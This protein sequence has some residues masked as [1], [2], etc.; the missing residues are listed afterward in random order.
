MPQPNI[1]DAVM[2]KS[3]SLPE[4]SDPLAEVLVKDSV[5]ARADAGVVNASPQRRH[6]EPEDIYKSSLFLGGDMSFE[7]ALLYNAQVPGFMVATDEQ[8]WAVEQMSK[9]D[10]YAREQLDEYNEMTFM[11]LDKIPQLYSPDEDA[12]VWDA[13]GRALWRGGYKTIGAMA[14]RLNTL[15]SYVTGETSTSFDLFAAGE[16][17]YFAAHP[18]KSQLQAEMWYDNLPNSKSFY[19]GVFGNAPYMIFTMGAAVAT[20]GGSLGLAAA[21]SIAYLVEGQEAYDRAIDGGA[22]TRTAEIAAN[23]VGSVNA[24]IELIQVSQLLKLNAAGA[25]LF[26]S[27]ASKVAMKKLNYT[28]VGYASRRLLSTVAREAVEEMLQGTVGDYA[29]KVLYDQETS[30]STW[31]NSRLNE[32]ISA[33]GAT[34]LFGV[35]NFA[36]GTR[37]IRFTQQEVNDITRGV[38]V[39]KAVKDLRARFELTE[40]QARDIATNTLIELESAKAVIGKDITQEQETELY[41]EI[42]RSGLDAS[43]AK[44]KVVSEL[45]DAIERIPESERV[46][47]EREA[48]IRELETVLA[49]SKKDAEALLDDEKTVSLTLGLRKAVASG[50]VNDVNAARNSL[51]MHISTLQKKALTGQVTTRTETTFGAIIVE[52]GTPVKPQLLNFL[53]AERAKRAEDKTNPSQRRFRVAAY[54]KAIKALEAADD[55]L[56]LT[57][58]SIAAA[59][60]VGV[61]SK[62][63][64]DI[65]SNFKLQD[66]VSEAHVP[67]TPEQETSSALTSQQKSDFG[68]AL[69]S[70]AVVEPQVLSTKVEVDYDKKI[71]KAVERREAAEA[72]G[73]KHSFSLAAHTIFDLTDNIGMLETKLGLPEAYSLSQNAENGFMHSRSFQTELTKRLDAVAGESARLITPE[74]QLKIAEYIDTR[75]EPENMDPAAKAVADELI[76]IDNEPLGGKYKEK[77]NRLLRYAQTKDTMG[78]KG[79]RLA[80]LKQLKYLQDLSGEALTSE[81]KKLSNSSETDFLVLTSYTKRMAQRFVGNIVGTNMFVEAYMAPSEVGVSALKSRVTATAA[82]AENFVS[83]MLHHYVLQ[84]RYYSMSQPINELWKL[85]S[86]HLSASS[87]KTLK[88]SLHRLVGVYDSPLTTTMLEVQKATSNLFKVPVSTGKL[89]LKQLIQGTFGRTTL[90][91][92]KQLKLFTASRAAFEKK[93]GKDLMNYVEKRILMERPLYREIYADFTKTPWSELSNAAKVIRT[94]GNNPVIV[95]MNSLFADYMA[96][97]HIALDGRNRLITMDIALTAGNDALKVKRL[98]FS[99]AKKKLGFSKLFDFQQNYLAELYSEGRIDELIL[100]NARFQT[101]RNQF[102]YIKPLR[103]FFSNTTIG[104]PTMQYATWWRN[105]TKLWYV[106]LSN[107]KS[108]DKWLKA[109]A[110]KSLATHQAISVVGGTLFAAL[111]GQLHGGRDFPEKLLNTAAAT[112]DPFSYSG[113]GGFNT[114]LTPLTIIKKWADGEQ[115]SQILAAARSFT[116]GVIDAGQLIGASISF[117]L[118]KDE[119]ALEDV[120]RNAAE[121][122]N[123]GEEY[124]NYYYWGYRRAT[125]VLDSWGDHRRAKYLRLLERELFG[126]DYEPRIQERTALRRIQ[127]ALFVT[128]PPVSTTDLHGAVKKVSVETTSDNVSESNVKFLRK[129]GYTLRQSLRVLDAFGREK[130][131]RKTSSG[132]V[133]LKPRYTFE[134]LQHKKSLLTRRWKNFAK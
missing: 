5:N 48:D 42:L 79:A 10:R 86:P 64:A 41:N 122:S 119:Q 85:V 91:L 6:L 23:V 40:A 115:P 51:L 87:A 77:Y 15:Q 27:R 71:T 111:V 31:I 69:T 83:E 104:T 123:I 89:L 46:E 44:A 52:P 108:G 131:E 130:V 112:L 96:D 94:V 93:Y 128:N 133:V 114:L 58:E 13:T 55:D 56:S 82:P 88:K 66:K 19:A 102:I 60:N 106:Q 24:V 9:R 12:S 75:I 7:Q 4:T 132:R 21:G 43:Q 8:T 103:D 70:P 16:A 47:L 126:L 117:A 25:K 80:K 2:S 26:A 39:E 50:N 116:R 68:D 57:K 125:A 98:P 109:E 29:A 107:L 28:A 120:K 20:G 34:L 32:A 99:E 97:A 95:W 90:A 113:V 100:E 118:T 62:I 35:P 73:R 17:T 124:L 127:N 14:R 74:Q 78:L 36:A 49:I 18:E 129:N 22:D 81:L 11:N 3:Q 33:A 134:T 54:D 63:V 110:A 45:D 38:N 37:G 84:D 67:A 1:L 59:L 121:L 105:Y 76:A 30:W 101:E 92:D 65:I 53:K 72:K 61:G